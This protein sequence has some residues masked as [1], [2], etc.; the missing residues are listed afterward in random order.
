MINR[1]Y[2]VKLILTVSSGL[3][4]LSGKI[5]RGLQAVSRFVEKTVLP[6]DTDL[7]TLIYKNPAT[8]DAG[9][10]DTTPRGQ[11][12]VMG[13]SRH[14]VNLAAWFL[15]VS[16]ETESTLKF[17]YND[18]LKLPSVERNTLLICYG[19]F[20]HNGLWKGIS[21]ASLLKQA[22]LKPGVTR[23]RF[24]GPRGI[25]KK[26]ATYTLEEV[27]NN[28]VFLAYHLNGEALPESM[29]FPLRLVAEGHY[30]KYWIKYVDEIQLLA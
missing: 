16:G 13:L 26:S 18:I 6:G 7:S 25:K 11:F 4:L 15:R 23:V 17:S 2:A 27:M 19:Y 24:S 22:G 21:S 8:L 29:G 30:G 5:G 9:Q 20:A 28:K 14:K 1:R 3:T 10:L 12:G